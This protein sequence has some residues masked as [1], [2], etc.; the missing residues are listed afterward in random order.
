MRRNSESGQKRSKMLFL[1]TKK[2]A[3]KPEEN[4]W[5]FF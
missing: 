5:L 3:K 1:Q 4:F 2:G